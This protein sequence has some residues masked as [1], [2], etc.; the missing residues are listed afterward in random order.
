MQNCDKNWTVFTRY[1]VFHCVRLYTFHKA[2]YL[3]AVWRACFLLSMFSHGF[4]FVTCL[5]YTNQLVDRK[6]SFYEELNSVNQINWIFPFLVS[7]L[8]FTLLQNILLSFAPGHHSLGWIGVVW[9][10]L[11]ELIIGKD[12]VTSKNSYNTIE[13]TL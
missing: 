1:N 13:C 8:H 11:Q 3:M 4:I 2:L 6:Y 5:Y 7:C 12:N 9:E 10:L